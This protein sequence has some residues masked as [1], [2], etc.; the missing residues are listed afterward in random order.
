[1]PET[2]IGL[3]PDVGGGYFLP[4]MSNSL[5]TFLGLS[6]YRLKGKELLHANIATHFVDSAQVVVYSLIILIFIYFVK[7]WNKT[8]QLSGL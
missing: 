2:A 8:Q 3:F 7:K 4:R 6:G 1:M 5:G